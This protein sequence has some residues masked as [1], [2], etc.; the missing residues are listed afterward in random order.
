MTYRVE[1]HFRDANESG[2]G[3][4]W[5][6]GGEEM[7]GRHLPGQAV[8]PQAALSSGSVNSKEKNTN[9]LEVV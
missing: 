1:S 4:G 3:E 9:K 2:G 6:V 5:R 8:F 7:V